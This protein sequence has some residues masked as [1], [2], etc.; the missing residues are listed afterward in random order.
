MSLP[1]Q[2]Q[3]SSPNDPQ[4]DPPLVAEL[5]DEPRRK[6]PAL[7]A[8]IVMI[9]FMVALALGPI[10]YIEVPRE[11]ARWHMAA[12]VE[13]RLDGDL[14]AAIESLNQ[15]LRRYPNQD[16]LYRQRAEW[17]E[18]NGEYRR[19]LTDANRA[20]ELAGRHAESFILRSQIYQHLK[21]HAEAIADWGV[22]L[23]LLEPNGRRARA[24]A[25]N[26]RAYARAVGNLELDAALED[27]DEALDTEPDSAAMLDT[28]GFIN[29]QLGDYEAA[30]VDM[31]RAVKAIEAEHD[32]FTKLVENGRLGV[33]DV[34]QF[35]LDLKQHAESVAVIR[36]HRSLVYEK[37]GKTDLAEEDRTRV[38]QLG[39]EPNEDLF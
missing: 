5:A 14:D 39:F 21:Q 34:R 18:E 26:G 31:Q 15:A 10:A 23:E 35:E 6:R 3:F 13:Q 7:W 20:I 11:I 1:T 2:P 24:M 19:A 27:I 32:A 30:D 37:L 12:A 36:Y 29:Y 16:E 17:L 38:R 4:S 9:G 33:S 28:R 22:V 25:L 8:G